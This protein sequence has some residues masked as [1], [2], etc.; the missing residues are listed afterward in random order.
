MY[1]MYSTL[2]T[3][4]K[5]PLL[6]PDQTSAV[7]PSLSGYDGC[8]RLDVAPILPDDDACG[9]PEAPSSQRGGGHGPDAARF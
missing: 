7:C 8:S 2:S 6:C 1:K 9:F 5:F 4:W 3:L